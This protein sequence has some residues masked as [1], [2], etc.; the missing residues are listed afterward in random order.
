M[1]SAGWMAAFADFYATVPIEDV[2]TLDPGSDCPSAV[3]SS[4]DPLPPLP[5]K[6]A[7]IQAERLPAE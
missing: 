4:A 5:S 7:G 2:L 3:L 1:A 6:H